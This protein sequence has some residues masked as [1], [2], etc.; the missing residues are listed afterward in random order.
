MTKHR[1][2]RLQKMKS[3]HKI[4]AAAMLAVLVLGAAA[5][6]GSRNQATAKKSQHSQSSTKKQS[7]Q[8]KQNGIEDTRTEKPS[9]SLS[10]ACAKIGVSPNGVKNT[11][12]YIESASW[13]GTN[14]KYGGMS[15]SGV[16]CSGLTNLIYKKVYGKSLSRS[17]AD[18]LND[19][20]KVI[21][22]SSLR[23]GDLVFFRTD[24]KKSKTPNH[25][26]IYLKEDKF[27]H[28][29]SSKGVIISSMTQDY[30]IRNFIAAGRTG[31]N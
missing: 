30:Y 16:D 6:S 15:R 8:K 9:G 19:N 13:I 5:C 2:K 25:V 17:S 7:Y 12:L 1:N 10:K 21:K 28:S 26:G 18:I 24:G 23:E 27:I 11:A 20:C 14:Y 3:L 4:V 31:V 22:K 29:S